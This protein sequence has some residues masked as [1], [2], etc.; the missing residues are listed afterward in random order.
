MRTEYFLLGLLICLASCGPEDRMPEVAG[1]DEIVLNCVTVMTTSQS[2]DVR[3][4]EVPIGF[5]VGS[6]G[7]W[8]GRL[9]SDFDFQPGANNVAVRTHALW[10]SLGATP[11]TIGSQIRV[12]ASSRTVIGVTP[13]GFAVPEGVDLWVPR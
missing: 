12:G 1:A 7:V 9:F 10:T 6:S 8:L 2:L 5:F 13:P 11:S 3:V 4:A